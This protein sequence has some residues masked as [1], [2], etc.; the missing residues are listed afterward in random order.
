MDARTHAKYSFDINKVTYLHV[1]LKSDN[2]NNIYVH[3]RARTHT[4]R[5][6]NGN[7]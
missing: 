1:K 4:H 6:M 5:G 3:V 2:N 7:R